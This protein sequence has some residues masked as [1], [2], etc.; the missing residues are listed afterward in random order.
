MELKGGFEE[1]SHGS[2]TDL[3]ELFVI[4]LVIALAVVVVFAIGEIL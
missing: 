3:N 4:L 1:M 2:G